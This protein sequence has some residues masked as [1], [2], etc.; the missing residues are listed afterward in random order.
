MTYAWVVVI[1]VQIGGL[2]DFITLG[3]GELPFLSQ[4]AIY[5]RR[6]QPVGFST[7]RPAGGI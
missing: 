2:S 6:K 1:H 7:F 5:L 4:N 3:N